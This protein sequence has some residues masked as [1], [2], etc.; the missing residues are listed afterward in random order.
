[1]DAVPVL[2]EKPGDRVEMDTLMWDANDRNPKGNPTPQT[3]R[4]IEQEQL[5]ESFDSHD[6]YV[7]RK[8]VN[9]LKD[10]GGADHAEVS[11]DCATGYLMGHLRKP[12]HRALDSVKEVV[13]EYALY[14]KSIKVL[15]AD[16]G[17]LAVSPYRLLTPESIK[18]LIESKVLYERAE[19]YN[20]SMGTPRAEVNIKLLKMKMRMAYRYI[21]SNSYVDK[22]PFSRLNILQLWGE[23]FHWAL[24]V[25]NMHPSPA[26]PSMTRSEAFT[27]VK[28]NMQQTRM[29]PIFCVVLVHLE[30]EKI[31]K[32]NE[33]VRIRDKLSDADERAK[34]TYGL[35]VGP[36]LG[37]PGAI[38][39]AVPTS[40][41]VKIIQGRDRGC[42]SR[43]D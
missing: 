23:V 6:V 31:T 13:A 22:L 21:E 32:K 11:V 29:L 7:E 24:F 8:R 9:K 43:H 30:P 17:F 14:G 25:M 3:A 20:H 36:E 5:L 4:E 37:T 16:S 18:F 39:I 15:A 35:Y 40:K 10:R 19:S 38:R 41:G 12:Q 34:Y 2:V 28:P 26:N 42:S 1:M 27:G 33:A